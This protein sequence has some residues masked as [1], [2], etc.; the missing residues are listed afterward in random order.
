V[1]QVTANGAIYFSSAAN[2]GNLTLG[3][4]GT[5]EGDFLANGPAGDPLT[6]AGTIHNFG[7]VNSPQNFDTLTATSSFISLKWSD[8]LG[9]S[10]NDYD[11]YIL[12]STGSTI[13]GFS[14]S[15]QTCT[16][17][18]YE[19]IVQGTNCGTPLARG[20]CPAVGDRI[21]VVLF[22]G[23]PRALRID[24]N[25]GMLSINTAGSTYGHNAGANTVSVAAT[26]WNSA[27]TG[28]R[29][30]TGFANPNEGFSSD[31]PRKI[32]YNP[33]GSA[34]T[35]DNFLFSTNGGTTLQKP[36]LAAADGVSCKTP[37]F[38]PFLGTSAAAPHAAGIA[39]LILSVQPMWT[40]AQ[41]LNAMTSTALDSMEPGVDRDS[42][43]GIA[44]ALPAVQYALT[45]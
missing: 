30:F 25:R 4:S 8:P 27:H 44:M 16:Q 6:G 3:T 42:G 17:D 12:D 26:Y 5:W 23:D 43:Y 2:S 41:V 34:I 13:K 20:Y 45:Q 7:T 35:P 39:A 29:P 24:T 10:C 21:V 33:D 9:G 14:A 37:G 38:L 40:P 19:L 28:V 1:N 15:S 11:L 36:D 31:G 32:F 18:P 22:N